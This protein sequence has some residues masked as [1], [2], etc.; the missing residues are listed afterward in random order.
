MGWDRRWTEPSWVQ[1][2]IT[3]VQGHDP[4]KGFQLAPDLGT[5]SLSKASGQIPC[6]GPQ[7]RRKALLHELWTVE[8]WESGWVLRLHG[9]E[10]PE[11]PGELLWGMATHLE[12]EVGLRETGHTMGRR[13]GCGAGVLC[14]KT[15]VRVGGR[16]RAPGPGP[17]P[18]SQAA[19]EALLW[20]GACPPLRVLKHLP[21]TLECGF[22]QWLRIHHGCW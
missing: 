22:F 2:Q 21:L 14:L 20:S 12:W 4:S 7:R 16:H 10:R 8:V 13:Q 6:R 15:T 19:L 9:A 17:V 5:N 3:E 18:V 1:G 11:K